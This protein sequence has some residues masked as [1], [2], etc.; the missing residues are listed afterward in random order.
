MIIITG[1]CAYG[2]MSCTKSNCSSNATPDS[3]VTIVAEEAPLSTS[4]RLMVL[5]SE[6]VELNDSLCY[7]IYYAMKTSDASTSEQ[8]G[9]VL[10]NYFKGNNKRNDC[11]N[12]FV[13][14]N[15]INKKEF[16]I[17][18][19]KCIDLENEYENYEELIN[20]FPMLHI[21]KEEYKKLL[22]GD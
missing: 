18:F 13:S 16:S 20:A 14:Q 12:S 17:L 11:I 9:Y 19:L 21:S 4:E 22:Q 3:K 7:S 1:M 6:E 5:L 8:L 2:S 15:N 10:Y